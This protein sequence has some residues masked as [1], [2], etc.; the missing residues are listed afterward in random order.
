[1]NL[2]VGWYEL[3]AAAAARKIGWGEWPLNLTLRLGRQYV[4]VGRGIVLGEYLDGGMIE[5][6][7]RDVRANLFAARSIESMD[8]RDRSVPGFTRSRRNVYGVE[9]TCQSVA[10]HQPYGFWVYQRDWSEE[11]PPDPLQ[12]YR[13][14]S[15]YVGVGLTG[16]LDAWTQYVVEAVWERGR[17]PAHLQTTDRER[18][19]AFAF[20][21]AVTRYVDHP[22]DPEIALEYA[23]ASGDD[24]RGTATTALFGNTAGTP[25]EAFLG[26]GY[27]N[28][29]L[30]LGARFTNLQFVR[31]G[32]RLTV[33]E[34]KVK[35]GRLDLGGNYYWL[36]KADSRG[37]ISDAM[38]V[39]TSA[40]I[41]QEIDVFC[42]WQ[43][44]S[45]VALSLHYGRFHPG[46]AYLDR[47]PRDFVYGAITFSF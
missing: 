22:M 5:L 30:A 39:K 11:T 26:F 8:N 17:S 29:G 47:Q 6:E 34:N 4:E 44:F 24:D 23:Y 13:Y 37:P 36:W 46:Q 33:Y 15:H 2:E 27:V 28:S 32:G 25:D 21:A 3:D 43:L 35:C 45:D 9:V 40:D 12:L 10:N 7:T 14:D 31:L 18:I 20:D 41:G 16:G 19:Q 38:A 1:M 42:E